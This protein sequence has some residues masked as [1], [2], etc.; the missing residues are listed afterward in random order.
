MIETKTKIFSVKRGQ[1]KISTLEQA[2]Y[3]GEIAEGLDFDDFAIRGHLDIYYLELA[4]AMG[5]LCCNRIAKECYFKAL[6]ESL[7]IEK[8]DE[9]L[10]ICK[11]TTDSGMIY[12]AAHRFLIEVD[13]VDGVRHLM[14]LYISNFDPE[15]S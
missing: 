7:K 9:L 2:K 14:E 15:E 5:K 11:K 8:S 12:R 10:G 13:T 4:R 3:Y 1:I 6:E